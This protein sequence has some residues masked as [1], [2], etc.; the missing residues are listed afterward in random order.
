[1]AYGGIGWQDEFFV[2][3]PNLQFTIPLDLALPLAWG[4]NYVGLPQVRYKMN[5]EETVKDGLSTDS[6]S[7][8]RVK[9]VIIYHLGVTDEGFGGSPLPKRCEWWQTSVLVYNCMPEISQWYLRTA[10]TNHYNYHC[11]HN[12]LFVVATVFRHHGMDSYTA[13]N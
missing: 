4:Y 9:K 5:Q 2:L 12:F 13:T 6:I 11:L 10:F 7:I 3:R 1:M 8:Q